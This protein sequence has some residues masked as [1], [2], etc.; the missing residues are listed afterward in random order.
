MIIN[1]CY[2]MTQCNTLC[3]NDS[4]IISFV[5]NGTIKI[6]FKNYTLYVVFTMGNIN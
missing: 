6:H 2:V 4:D 5:V 3:N 1:I